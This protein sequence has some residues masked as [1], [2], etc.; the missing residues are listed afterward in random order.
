MAKIIRRKLSWK[1]SASAQTIG[2]KLYWSQQG[3][4]GYESDC[5]YL[6][7]VLEVIIPD[8]LSSFK[9]GTGPFDFGLTAVDDS[10]NESDM[11]TLTAPFHFIA[12]VPPVEMHIGEVGT[13]IKA[14]EKREKI[15]KL[16]TRTKTSAPREPESASS[17]DELSANSFEFFETERADTAGIMFTKEDLE[18]FEADLEL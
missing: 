11:T 12:P 9:P 3:E 10:G 5:E 2:Y 16:K 15:L 13:A 8:G 17:G 1:V 4:L 6:G 7:N 18:I 14:P